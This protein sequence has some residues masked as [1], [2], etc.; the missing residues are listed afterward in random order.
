MSASIDCTDWGRKGFTI[1]K[2]PIPVR[3]MCT[4]QGSVKPFWSIVLVDD[5]P[6]AAGSTG[7]EGG[8]PNNAAAAAA[9]AIHNYDL[10]LEEE[11]REPVYDTENIVVFCVYHNVCLT[12]IRGIRG[13]CNSACKHS[14]SRCISIQ[15]LSVRAS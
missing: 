10:N 6:A 5:V 14:R 15:C 9:I 13:V 7:V 1:M 2:G 3:N 8:P 4:H 12:A 11:T